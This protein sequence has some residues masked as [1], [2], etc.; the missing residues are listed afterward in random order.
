MNRTAVTRQVNAPVEAVFDAVAHIQNFQTIVPDIV[1]VE[2]LTEQHTDVGTRFRETRMMGKREAA[3][4]LEVTEYQ[5]HEHVRMG[6]DAGGTIWDSTFT[7]KARADG[8]TD[9]SLVMD[10]NAYR[11]AA[12][13]FNPLIK[14]M[15]R[16]AIEKDM[17]AV[18]AH[19]EA[20]A[21]G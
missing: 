1:K 21:G 5:P 2:F 19:C 7:T 17:D 20:Q 3:T 13:L 18:K 16:K 11:F 6:A 15:V 14:G 4:E 9:L 10:A 12:K 8:G